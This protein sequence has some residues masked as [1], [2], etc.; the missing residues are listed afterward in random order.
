VSRDGTWRPLFTTAIAVVFFEGAIRKWAIPAYADILY[1]SKDAALM[2][3][4]AAF[5]FR[6][7][8]RW[9]QS[10]NLGPLLAAYV[11]WVLIEAANPNLPAIALGIFGAKAHAFYIMIVPL[12]FEA[13]RTRR[14]PTTELIALYIG[15]IAIPILLLG[16]YQFSQP[17]SSWINRYTN[18][19]SVVGGIATVGL[20]GRPRI[21][22]TFSY[23][24]GMTTFLM[25]N[26]ALATGLLLSGLIKGGRSLYLG[27][28][29][30][31]LCFFVAPMNGSRATMY[32]PAVA[33][34]VV[35]I[36][37][38]RRRALNLRAI[39]LGTATIAIGA[40]V[41]ARADA[42]EGW[43][44][45]AERVNSA[46]DVNARALDTIEG[47]IRRAQLAGLIGFGAG[48]THQAAPAIVRDLAP[49]SWLPTTNFE[50]E[51]GRV[52]LELGL[53]GMLIY[54]ALKLGLCSVALTAVR[55]AQ[56]EDELITS[57]T[58]FVYFITHLVAAVVFNATA[59]VIYWALAGACFAI[60]ASQTRAVAQ[61][62]TTAT[63]GLKESHQIDDGY[64]QP[65]RSTILP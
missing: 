27:I 24:S 46:G 29:L 12:A 63:V 47:P 2:L 45:F 31:A 5:V 32:L 15:A 60:R 19:S 58:I 38:V 3:A 36:E 7:G 10:S 55:R 49:F 18:E 37:L 53:I 64:R 33:A 54:L 28:L 61:L 42:L 6:R 20:A 56:S 9:P 59:G 21:T 16:A 14:R 13:Y 44:A 52:A 17:S 25:L 8:W 1:F 48:S 34:P 22:G 26:I 43:R 39:A 40:V 30:A 11:I 51:T 41:V 23:L 35:V 62:H 50:E 65:S 57:V 4:I